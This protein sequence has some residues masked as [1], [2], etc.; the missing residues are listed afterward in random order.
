MKHYI[1]FSGAAYW[2]VMAFAFLLQSFILRG[3]P[4]LCWGAL[5]AALLLLPG[6]IIAKTQ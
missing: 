6:Y 5:L 4:A 3:S 2:P 1:Q